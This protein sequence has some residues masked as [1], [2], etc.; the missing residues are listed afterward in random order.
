VLCRYRTFPQIVI[1]EVH[2]VSG[3]PEVDSPL[4]Q[5]IVQVGALAVVAHLVE[6]GLS[7]IH[8]GEVGPMGRGDLWA[9]QSISHHR[10]R[11][12]GLDWR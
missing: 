10:V 1:N 2:P 5:L 4:H 7:D 12:P 6:R 9:R 3:P 11:P 8:R